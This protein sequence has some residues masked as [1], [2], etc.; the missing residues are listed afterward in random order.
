MSFVRKKLIVARVYR[1]LPSTATRCL[2]STGPDRS[3]GAHGASQHRL[4]IWK[5]LCA[6][7]SG[8]VRRSPAAPIAVHASRP[9]YQRAQ[10]AA[11]GEDRQ[12]ARRWVVR[13]DCSF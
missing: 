8:R 11:R 10:A 13:V 2:S 3:H 12:G 5:L 4:C 9:T 1:N 7:T 6:G